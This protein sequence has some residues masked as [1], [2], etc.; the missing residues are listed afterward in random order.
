MK[1]RLFTG[2]EENK[3]INCGKCKRCKN[4]SMNSWHPDPYKEVEYGSLLHKTY[5]ELKEGMEVFK[6]G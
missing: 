5:G 4:T 2:W 1:V 3:Y 6:N